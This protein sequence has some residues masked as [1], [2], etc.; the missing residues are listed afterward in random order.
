MLLGQHLGRGHKGSLVSTLNAHEQRADGND[1]LSGSNITL[2]E[3][4]HWMRTGEV[5]AQFFN[6]T[7]LSLGERKR[8]RFMEVIQ[9]LARHHVTDALRLALYRPLSHDEDH[10]QSKQFVERQPPTSR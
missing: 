4:M 2:Q 10:L 1:G 3:A 5:V 9:E 6:G 7:G 8:Q